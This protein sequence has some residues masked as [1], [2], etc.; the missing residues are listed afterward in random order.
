MGC[1]YVMVEEVIVWLGV[2][3]EGV[4]LFF[5]LIM[6]VDEKVKVVYLLYGSEIW[7]VLCWKN[8]ISYWD[9]LEIREVLRKV[10]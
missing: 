9:S 5:N 7:E 10:L 3:Y 1:V 8:V 2:L 6:E 4:R